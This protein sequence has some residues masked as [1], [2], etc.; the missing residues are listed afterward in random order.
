MEILFEMPRITRILG[1]R[2]STLPDFST[3]CGRKQ[4][5]KMDIWRTFLGLASD[6]DN[7]GE[8][9]A[10]DATWIASPQASTMRKI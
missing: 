6:L 9:Q 5:L 2:P 7:L 8:I 3:V 4:E 1:L 10:I